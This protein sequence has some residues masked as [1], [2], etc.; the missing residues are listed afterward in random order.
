MAIQGQES[1]NIGYPNEPSGSDSLYTAFTK[2]KTNF[3]TLFACASPYSTITGNT[4]I[5]VNTNSNIG[6]LD[7]Y[8]SGVV[9]LVAGTGISLAGTS[10]GGVYT[11]NITIS[12]IGVVGNVSS[13]GI[14]SS[15]LEITGSPI[16]SS[17]NINVE[18]PSDI[19][20]S[21]NLT[22][23][24]VSASFANVGN[25]DTTELISTGNITGSNL[26]ASGNITTTNTI[27]ANNAEITGNLTVG[28]ISG[29]SL[30]GANLISSNYFSSLANF[31][32][33]GNMQFA[34][35]LSQ[36]GGTPLSSANSVITHKIPIVINGTTYYI[37]LTAAQ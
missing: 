1:I 29:G 7:I 2:I 12:A 36:E 4:G 8:N 14:T 3:E 21:G 23:D 13:V 16:T 15:T 19:T 20:I 34:A 35:N 17:G 37:A 6:T 11:G 28:G 10:N 27:S 25:L 22:A 18:L 33:T 24:S 9:G 5:I 31:T 26:I 32:A 30:T